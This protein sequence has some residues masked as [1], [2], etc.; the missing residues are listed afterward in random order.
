MSSIGSTTRHA[1]LV[2]SWRVNSSRLPFMASPISPPI[3][4]HVVGRIIQHIQFDV[5]ADYIITRRLSTGAY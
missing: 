2:A 5:F 1:S 4:Q 3:K